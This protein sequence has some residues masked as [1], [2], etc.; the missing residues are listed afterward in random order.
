[1]RSVPIV[2]KIRC[3][4]KMNSKLCVPDQE[5]YILMNSK[6]HRKRCTMFAVVQSHTF[7]SSRAYWLCSN[8]SSTNSDLSY[9]KNCLHIF[10]KSLNCM[11]SYD[12]PQE[13]KVKCTQDFWGQL[14]VSC[15]IGVC[16]LTFDLSAPIMSWQWKTKKHL[17]ECN[18]SH[19]NLLWQD[20]L[21]SVRKSDYGLLP[22]NGLA[23]CG[24]RVLVWW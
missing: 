10:R 21:G 1:M 5:V 16:T 17:T 4:R 7:N 18:S 9:W 2:R 15:G 13:L 3:K 19:N 6:C 20:Q 8:D 23:I 22:R 11:K 12:K 24:S 14:S